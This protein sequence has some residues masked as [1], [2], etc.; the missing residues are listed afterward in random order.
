MGQRG[1]S[2]VAQ[3][4]RLWGEHPGLL[5]HYHTTAIG[6]LVETWMVKAILQRPHMAM[7][8]GRELRIYLQN[9][10]IKFQFNVVG[11]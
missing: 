10:S 8:R 7:R 5:S 6:T 11:Q 3:K 9:S 2:A 1:A 4:R